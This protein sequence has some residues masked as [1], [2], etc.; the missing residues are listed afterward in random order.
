MPASSHNRGRWRRSSGGTLRSMKIRLT[1]LG[2][3]IPSGWKRSPGRR[4]RRCR[5]PTRSWTAN[6]SEVLSRPVRGGDCRPDQQTSQGPT[7]APFHKAPLVR[8][9][10]N[11]P[12]FGVS[13][14]GSGLHASL[15]KPAQPLPPDTVDNS[16]MVHR[17]ATSRIPRTSAGRRKVILIAAKHASCVFCALYLAFDGYLDSPMRLA[18]MCQPR[19]IVA[20]LMRIE[21]VDGGEDSP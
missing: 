1:F 8:A 20:W 12:D 16:G 17:I 10:T 9:A 21:G 6:I 7:D 11:L 18:A 5:A 4:V 15:T 2:C 19:P 3:A 13:G 14:S